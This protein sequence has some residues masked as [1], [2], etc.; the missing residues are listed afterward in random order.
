MHS[1]QR[2]AVLRALALGLRESR[3]T[4]ASTR[5]S[6]KGEGRRR[7]SALLQILGGRGKGVLEGCE[8]IEN[9][10]PSLKRALVAEKDSLLE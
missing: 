3:R 5:K 7:R 1:D 10:T 8:D 2:A 6:L 9:S 4:A